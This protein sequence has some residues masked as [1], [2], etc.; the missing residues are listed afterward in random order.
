MLISN[1]LLNRFSLDYYVRL[2][3]NQQRVIQGLLG[4]WNR[5]LTAQITNCLVP[6]NPKHRIHQIGAS[7]S[8]AQAEADMLSDELHM[9]SEKDFRV[10]HGEEHASLR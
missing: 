4:G 3:I 1:P 2:A 10:W 7:V 9:F 8:L 5:D 6:E